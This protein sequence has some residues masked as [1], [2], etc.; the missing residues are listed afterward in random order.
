MRSKTF[1]T[2][3]HAWRSSRRREQSVPPAPDIHSPKR[4]AQGLAGYAEIEAASKMAQDSAGFAD[5]VRDIVRMTAEM[6][7]AVA[8]A[9][10][11]N[12]WKVSPNPLGAIRTAS[13][14]EAKRLGIW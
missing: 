10:R 11:Q 1:S 4:P 3:E 12:R 5:F 2:P 6:V 14:Q 8:E 13:H 9:I 7:P